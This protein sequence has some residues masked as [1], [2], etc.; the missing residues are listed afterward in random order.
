MKQILRKIRNRRR[1]L[2]YIYCK[3]GKSRNE[4]ETGIWFC[5]V[6]CGTGYGDHDVYSEHIYRNPD[7]SA[8]PPC[9]ISAFLLLILKKLN[10]IH[11]TADRKKIELMEQKARLVLKGA[12]FLKSSGILWMEGTA[13]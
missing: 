8:V 10:N 3:R 12:P 4:D 6:F 1:F 13:R 9:R 7:R 11:F 5:T 2:A